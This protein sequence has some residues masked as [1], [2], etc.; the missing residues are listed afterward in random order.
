MAMSEPSE[1]LLVVLAG[2]YREFL[3]WCRENERNP[4]DR[5]LKYVDQAY[6]LQGMSGFDHIIYGTFWDRRDSLEIYSAMRA[7]LEKR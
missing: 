6:K 7:R 1:H 2:N 4:S 3:F 5:N